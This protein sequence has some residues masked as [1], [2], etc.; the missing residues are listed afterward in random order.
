MLQHKIR[1]AFAASIAIN[2]KG[3]RYLRTKD[4]VCVLQSRGIHFS[5]R[6][7]N[8]WIERN[9]TYFVDKTTDESENRLWMLRNMGRVL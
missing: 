4:F 1:E 9:Q 6:E 7:A 8:Q 5:G 2:P 3:Y